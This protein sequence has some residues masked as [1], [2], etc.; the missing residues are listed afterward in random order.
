[1][2]FGI[3]PMDGLSGERAHAATKLGTAVAYKMAAVY[4]ESAQHAVSTAMELDNS[5]RLIERYVLGTD[6]DASR[7]PLAAPIE[8]NPQRYYDFPY[9][10]GADTWS[11]N[12]PIPAP[13]QFPVDSMDEWGQARAPASSLES[14]PTGYGKVEELGFLSKLMG[15]MG[16]Q[17][18]VGN[19]LLPLLPPPQLP[20]MAARCSASLPSRLTSRS[21]TSQLPSAASVSPVNAR[22]SGRPAATVVRNSQNKKQ[23]GPSG[24]GRAI[25]S[26]SEFL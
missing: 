13:P 11:T 5:R 10:L 17:S 20:Q 1:M 26:I 21:H 15:G 19:S 9:R 24:P 8:E 18:D 12:Y 25:S 7:D 3:Y 2:L 16:P 4:N 23:R 22:D 14:G 6:E